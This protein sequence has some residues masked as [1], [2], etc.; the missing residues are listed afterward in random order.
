MLGSTGSAITLMP[1]VNRPIVLR[2]YTTGAQN[3]METYHYILLIQ[4]YYAVGIFSAFPPV[5][6][7][8][9]Q[10][11]MAKY[12]KKTYVISSAQFRGFFTIL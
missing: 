5:L 3:A 6:Y 4:V 8:I 11:K 2:Q 7:P 9:K 10:I 1:C 12:Y